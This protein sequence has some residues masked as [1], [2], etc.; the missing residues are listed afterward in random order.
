MRTRGLSVMVTGASSGIGRETATALARG[1]AHVWAVARSG[2]LLDDLAG[3][4]KGITALVGDLTTEADRAAVVDAAGP[5][6]V[7]VNNAGIGWLGRVEEMPAA[8]V[9]LLF[10]LNVLALIDLTQR[11][12]PGMLARRRGHVVNVASVAS[13][14]AMPPLTVYAA[15]KFA[16]Q[17]FSDGLRRELSGRG[18]SVATINPGPV[19]TRFGPRAQAED[20]A[21]EDLGDG[22]MAGVPPSLVARAVVRSL[23]R[24][25]WPGYATIAVP[26]IVGASR[27][28][29]VPGLRWA[30]DAAALASR[31]PELYRRFG[32]PS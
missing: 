11:V 27:L 3:D 10:E 7:L 1:G 5:I 31:R 29:A 13:W 17:G 18:V 28:G 22:L 25:G 4:Q 30:V 8:E 12:V 20:R 16:V 9:R 14:V 23:R 24:A 26:R 21:S 15:T 19:A 2:D 6:D 32:Q